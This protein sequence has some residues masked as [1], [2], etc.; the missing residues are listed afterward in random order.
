MTNKKKTKRRIEVKAPSHTYLSLSFF[1]GKVSEVAER[2]NKFI[3]E[4][5][6]FIKNLKE[7]NGHKKDPMWELIND[8]EF[9]I[10]YWHEDIDVV[11]R[12]YRDETDEEFEKRIESDIKKSEAAKKRAENKKIEKEKKDRLLYEQLKKK[13]G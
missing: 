12:Y 11:V 5:K 1:E 10:Q 6:E 2:I 3:P 9:D 8:Y 7:E 13:F 4:H